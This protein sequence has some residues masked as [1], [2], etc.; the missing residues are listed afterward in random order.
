M[1][2]QGVDSVSGEPTWDVDRSVY[3]VNYMLGE[4]GDRKVTI[5]SFGR[6]KGYE[7]GL[8]GTD[9]QV[10]YGEDGEP[11]GVALDVENGRTL[12]PWHAVRL[13]HVH[14]EDDE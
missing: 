1:G 2:E 14:S 10:V 4:I 3:W 6:P 12:F 7:G 13:I 11:S 9:L 5:E 8:S